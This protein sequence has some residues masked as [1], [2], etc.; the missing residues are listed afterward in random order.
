[1]LPTVIASERGEVGFPA[2]VEILRSGGTALDAVQAAVRLVEA[3]PD[4]HYVGV[5]GLPNLLGEV[6][7]DAMLMDGVTRR[8]GAVAAVQG[9]PHPIDIARAVLDR[10]PQHA[11]LVGRGA[12]RFADECGVERGATLT[13]AAVEIWRA[14]LG[15]DGLEE[16]ALRGPGDVRYRSEALA[17]IEAMDPP[18]PPWGTVNVIALDASGG[19]AIGVST[20]GYPWKYP[21]RVGDSAVPGAGGWAVAAGAAGCTGRGELTVRAG[22]ARTV[23][24]GL[25]S[26]LTPESACVT[27]L[28]ALSDLPDE[29]RAPVQTLCLLPDGRHAAAGTHPGSTYAAQTV[30]EDVPR[31]LP[32]ASLDQGP[33]HDRSY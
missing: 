33:E 31:I 30:D 22:T 32:R 23:V 15:P 6:E 4:D 26:G 8:V 1:M 7:L 10:L 12:E 21:G 20:S 25:R 14:G 18:P 29:F 11:L 17:R 28:A 5:G 24:D 9:F 27:A 19:L 3:N 2:A 16:A 13:A